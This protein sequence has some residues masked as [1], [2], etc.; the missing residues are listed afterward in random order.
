MA[1]TYVNKKY[2]ETDLKFPKLHQVVYAKTVNDMPA[3]TQR[4]LKDHQVD[5][6]LKANCRHPYYRSPGYLHEK[7]VQFECDEDATFFALR[8][9]A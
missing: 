8:W 2:G 4:S 5:E 9:A 7:F 6:W 3:W 1:I